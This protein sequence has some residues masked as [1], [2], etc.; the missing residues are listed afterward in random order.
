MLQSTFTPWFIGSIQF[1]KFVSVPFGYFGSLRFLYVLL[2]ASFRY[3]FIR[4]VFIFLALALPFSFQLKLAFLKTRAF[5]TFQSFRFFRLPP[6][7][8]TI[9][10][11]HVFF[12]LH[13]LKSFVARIKPF[14]LELLYLCAQILPETLNVIVRPSTLQLQFKF[15]FKH[16]FLRST[17][18]FHLF[19]TQVTPASQDPLAPFCTVFRQAFAKLNT[20]FMLYAPKIRHEQ[21]LVPLL[22]VTSR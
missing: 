2:F 20:R 10:T 21:L 5:S 14:F 4:Y 16:V 7:F 18:I 11:H 13:A 15:P 6:P 12:V 19:A 8:L 17:V 9:C 1:S 3:V 22:N